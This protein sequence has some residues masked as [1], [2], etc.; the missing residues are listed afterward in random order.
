MVFYFKEK[1][2]SLKFS[3]PNY[4]HLFH[5]DNIKGDIKFSKNINTLQNYSPFHR[6][7]KKFLKIFQAHENYIASLLPPSQQTP[8]Q[9]QAN[10][11]FAAQR[12]IK[13]GIICFSNMQIRY[14]KDLCEPCLN[15]P[16]KTSKNCFVSIIT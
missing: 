5:R 7:I 10:G 13:Q 14:L 3:I 16:E 11:R 9:S 15:A 12:L 8:I 6:F 1:L 4:I 2:D